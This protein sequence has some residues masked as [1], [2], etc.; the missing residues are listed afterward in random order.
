LA[1]AAEVAAALAAPSSTTLV[2][3]AQRPRR[4]TLAAAVAAG[5]AVIAGAAVLAAVWLPRRG[6]QG[7][8]IR[9]ASREAAPLIRQLADSGRWDS[10]YTVAM[11]ARAVLPRDSAL[12][13]LWRRFSDTVTIRTEPAGARVYWKHYAR[14]N[15][16]G[17]LLGTTPIT[18]ARIPFRISRL[19]IAKPGLHPLDVLVWPSFATRAPFLLEGD[20]ARDGGMVR[21]AGGGTELNLPGLDHLDSLHLADFLVGRFEVTN[22][23]F[24]RFVESG[25]YRQRELWQHPFVSNGHTLAW[26]EGIAR[27]T[28]KTGR[29]GPS[30]WE[31][32]TYAEDQGN[33]PVTGVSW[34]EAAAYAAF[35]GAELPTI[36]HWSRAAFTWGGAAIVPLSNFSG[37]GLS[38]VG[39]Y[40]G[41]GPFG[42]Y[43]MAGNAREWC[44]NQTGSERYILGGGWND[45]PYAFN[46]AYA[47]DPFDR[48]AT[49]GFRLTKYLS[50]D[51]L[52]NARRPIVRAFRDFAKE[53]PV[54]DQVFAAYRRMYDYDRT[55]LNAVIDTTDEVT[56]DWVRQEISFDA[57]Y[58]QE[59]MA[60]YLYVPK[61]GKPPYQAVVFFPGSN[62]IHGR[63]S[64]S[65]ITASAFDFII[66]SGR[67][68]IHPIY[69]STY[70]RHDSLHSDYPDESN[71]Y[72]EHVIAWAKDLRR[73]IDYLGTRADIDT[74]RVAYFGV[75]W[76][77][78]LGGLMPAVEPRFKA[79][80]LLVAGLEYQR[81][82]P[83][84][85]PINFLPRVTMPVLM[86]NGQYDHYFPV[87]T[88]QRPMFRL[89][90]TPPD[91]KRQVIAEG[92]HFVPRTQV[93]KE[94]LDWLDRYLG[95]VR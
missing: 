86:L 32:G 26:S 7:A 90:G 39:K 51:N 91:R 33:D 59:R 18:A 89:L 92:G 53:R 78:Y 9:W 2:T 69:L 23:E 40:E 68:V 49:N 85:D 54:S 93:V 64:G 19:H 34:Y 62:A 88:A 25:G 44:F 13:S 65:Q 82:L 8:E 48:S 3:P 5:A 4:W 66:Q 61:H 11:R 84:A 30:T 21:V 38:P 75:S 1:T 42:T 60:A 58:N 74:S 37:R 45:P 57:A 27:F 67:A 77:G 52:A 6:G 80:V 28:D 36:Y 10:A 79:V 17:V 20:S 76:G 72:K 46:D 41:V 95:V 63:S 71:F 14:P 15:E 94:T 50:D 56:D 55:K 83:E 87:E 47:Q 24:K 31:G 70:E 35:A 43:D 16:P 12:T 29:P 81:A 73:S 22:K